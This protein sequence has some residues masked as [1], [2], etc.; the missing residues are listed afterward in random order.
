M[1]FKVEKIVDNNDGTCVVYFDLNDDF[2][3]EFVEIM[4]L[5][6]WSDEFF[7]KFVHKGLEKLAE[8]EK[9]RLKELEA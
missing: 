7:S 2:K 6:K 8:K 9:K 5:D 3:K 1:K 4:D